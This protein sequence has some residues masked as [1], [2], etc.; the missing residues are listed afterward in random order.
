MVAIRERSSAKLFSG[1]PFRLHD[2]V[3][4]FNPRFGGAGVWQDFTDEGAA[5]NVEIHR[6]GDVGAHFHAF[7]A[8]QAALDFAKLNKLV[9]EGFRHI[10]WN[11]KAD[12]D[13]AAARREDRGVD[14]DKLAVEVQ[15]R[16]AG[17]AAVNRGVGLNEILQPFKV[18]AAAAKGQR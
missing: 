2:D 8:Q 18:Q 4:G 17:V 7:N 9:G 1:L 5:L 14:P 15:Q 11:G 12:A 16:A 10:A 3:P 6:F 13:A